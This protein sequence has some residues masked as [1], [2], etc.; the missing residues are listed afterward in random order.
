M[1]NRSRS[2]D[3]LLE[4]TPAPAPPNTISVVGLV[5]RAEGPEDFMFTAADGQMV[6]LKREAVKGHAVLG[7]AV[8]QQIV[9]L[10]LDHTNL[11]ADTVKALMQSYGS[12]NAPLPTV[13]NYDV[14]RVPVPG[15]TTSF[16]YDH[17]YTYGHID[18][19][20]PPRADYSAPGLGGVAPFVAAFP[21]HV[22]P[23]TLAA[24]A[25]VSGP[26]TYITANE[27]TSDRHPVYKAHF[28][29]P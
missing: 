14:P 16:Y 19:G 23:D 29:Q 22:D 8:G 27:W 4:E 25:L 15:G 2:F 5:S 24:L 9:R 6:L 26:R 20:L 12:G 18:V 7:G 13:Q 1:P 21:H 10:D 28:D 11:P 17:Y 3:E